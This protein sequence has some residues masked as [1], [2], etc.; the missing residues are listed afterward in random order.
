MIMKMEKR[1]CLYVGGDDSNHAG[2]SQG[3]IIVAT[4][5]YNPADAISERISRRRDLP[6]V[7]RWLRRPGSDYRF[8]ILT[9]EKY[10]HSGE[11]LV[12]VIPD[13]V[14]TFIHETQ[15]PDSLNISLD[16]ELSESSRRL[17]KE[18]FSRGRIEV[19]V[20]NFEKGRIKRPYTTRMI[21][22]ADVLANS[23]YK[24]NTFEELS[25]HK[26]LV[27]RR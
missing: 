25:T 6:E 14:E 10:R 16:G 19:V 2:F 21:Y 11:N 20:T 26:K 27:L 1:G 18:R 9:S 13:L 23:L 12:I 15:M 24:N 5:S 3:E 8:A 4:F 7:M 17:I 22:N